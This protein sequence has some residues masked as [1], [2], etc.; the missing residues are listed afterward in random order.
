MKRGLLLLLI[1]LAHG[2]I[3]LLGNPVLD[4]FQ[5]RRKLEGK[6]NVERNFTEILRFLSGCDYL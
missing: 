2:F 1:G 6:L 5:N 4:R 3:R